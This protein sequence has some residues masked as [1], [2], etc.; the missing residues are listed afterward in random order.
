MRLRGVDRARLRRPSAPRSDH[1]GLAGERRLHLLA[2]HLAKRRFALLREDQGDRPSL[3]PFDDRVDVHEGRA[4]PLRHELAHG[5]LARPRQADQHDVP[6]HDAAPLGVRARTCAA[7]PSKFRLVSLNASPPN[8]SSRAW[9]SARAIIASAM[10]PMAG[11]A[12]TT[13]RSVCGCAA[14]PVFRSTVRS[15]DMSVE[16]GFIATRSE[17]HTSELQ[18]LAYLVCR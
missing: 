3:A 11:T 14:P 12:V 10:T 15:G 2:L 17:E 6:F 1:R 4:Q 13:H 8:F 9:A 5:G 18:S 7:Y 16:I